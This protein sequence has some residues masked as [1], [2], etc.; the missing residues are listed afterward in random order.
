MTISRDVR[1]RRVLAVVLRLGLGGL[2]LT[3]GLLKLRDPASFAAEIANYQ[4]FPSLAPYL[5]AALPTTEVVVGLG[6]VVLPL[7]WRRGAAAAGLTLFGLFGVA[8]ASAY[9]RHIDIA[10]GCFGG[11]GS[12]INALTIA[13]NVSLVLATALLLAVD[14]TRADPTALYFPRNGPPVSR[15][16]P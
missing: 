7:H 5:A 16:W 1:M 13:R 3:A 6:L 11:G 9:I 8:V 15:K 10:C 14:S 4:L 12:S 2:L